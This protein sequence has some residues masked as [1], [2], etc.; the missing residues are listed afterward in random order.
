MAS[1][2]NN[3]EEVLLHGEHA[4]IDAECGGASGASQEA[5][6][7]GDVDAALSIK[8][9]R[10]DIRCGRGTCVWQFAGGVA[11]NGTTNA[12]S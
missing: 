6:P 3:L 12:L 4:P 2:V 9:H 1:S 10:T 11:V 5:S 8:P 7:S